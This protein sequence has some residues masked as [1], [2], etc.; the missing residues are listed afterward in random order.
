MWLPLYTSPV[1]VWE[2][3]LRRIKQY[4][5]TIALIEKLLPFNYG[6]CTFRRKKGYRGM[7]FAVVLQSVHNGTPN[8][9][10]LRIYFCAVNILVSSLCQTLPLGTKTRS[11]SNSIIDSIAIRN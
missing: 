4:Y 5:D 1:T 11:V 9:D 6:K 2:I 10:S 8:R 3:L 7:L